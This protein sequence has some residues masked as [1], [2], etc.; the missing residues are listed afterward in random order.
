MTV[1]AKRTDR[2]P[3]ITVRKQEWRS[4][5]SIRTVN[6]K[7]RSVSKSDGPCETYGPSTANNGPYQCGSIGHEWKFWRHLLPDLCSCE[8]FSRTA[9]QYNQQGK[10]S[11]TS[12]WW[13]HKS[14]HRSLPEDMDWFGNTCWH[15]DL[16]LEQS[17]F[18][19]I[20]RQTTICVSMSGVNG[21]VSI[22]L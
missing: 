1:C 7:S 4:V 14:P 9:D 15:I 6:R 11:W 19:G 3:Q 13:G 8:V 18:P 16:V 10:Y 12:Q 20:Q 21:S 22:I 5:R 17:F 2:Q